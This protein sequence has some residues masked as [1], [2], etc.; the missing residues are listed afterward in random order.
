MN[1]ELN[2]LT[3][4]IVCQKYSQS[5]QNELFLEGLL[6]RRE[7]S[8]HPLSCHLYVVHVWW[9]TESHGIKFTIIV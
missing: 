1:K 7:F 4:M 3:T 6:T 8:C 5:L 9:M 2:V